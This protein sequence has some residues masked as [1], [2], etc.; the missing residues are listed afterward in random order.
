M[1]RW[2]PSRYRRGVYFR[3]VHRLGST[4]VHPFAKNVDNLLSGFKERVFYIDS[5]GTPRPECQRRH[6]ELLP[7]ALALH[8]HL[9]HFHRVTSREFVAARTGAKR[10]MYERALESMRLKRPSLGDMAQLKFF[11][12]FESTLWRK[13]QVPRIISPR[14]PEFNILLGRYT[15]PL[16]EHVYYALQQWFCSA[17]PVVAKGL[18]Q[19]AKA[20]AIVEKLRP[21]WCA[22][23]LDASR[24]D[25]CIQADL[26]KAEH[27]F[28]KMVYPNDRLL[29]ALLR[30]Q[31]HNRGY[32]LCP[33]GMVRADIGAMRCSGDQNTS[34]GNI[35]IMCFLI[36]LFCEENGVF[37]YDVL[38]D[39]DD[40]LLF[41]PATSLP[42]LEG[43]TQWYLNWGLRMKVEPPAYYPEQVEF[44]QSKPVK[45]DDGWTLIRQ[46]S[47]ALNTDYACGAT[48]ARWEDYL[49]HIRSVGLCGL[50]M[51]AGCPIY[52][53]FYSWGVANGKTGKWS[54]AMSR[55]IK[56]QAVIQQR[57]GHN[58]FSKP[59]SLEARV[60]FHRAFGIAPEVQMLVE[61]HISDML[62]RRPTTTHEADYILDIELG[63]I[64]D[65]LY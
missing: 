30:E 22:V 20:E 52:D 61:E 43:L 3:A 33:D 17:C 55:G 9:P 10:A 34:L 23:G 2:I 42:L 56:R 50:S 49:V 63:K 25:Q 13:P 4:P 8:A 14:S 40:L 44:C 58:A 57:A 37:S 28:Y 60:S 27:S 18:T 31:L 11:T 62:L 29:G 46:P 15:Q 19:Q 21:G 47:K 1:K 24:F 39:G 38:D 16:E 45:L 54:D 26:L 64:V 5:K 7:L 48:A 32:G 36:R 53:R 65:S 59:V 6:T 51:A 35:L 12:K 41:L